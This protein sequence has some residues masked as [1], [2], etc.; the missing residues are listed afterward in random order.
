MHLTTEQKIHTVWQSFQDEEG[1]IERIDLFAYIE[2]EW[3]SDGGK[4]FKKSC[5]I[6]DTQQGTVIEDRCFSVDS[7]KLERF[8]Q[9][10]I[11]GLKE[12]FGT[13]IQTSFEHKML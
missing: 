2:D 1:N 12:N 13:P 9:E 5:Q 10:E 4:T 6:L 8:I 11:E 3:S 7:D